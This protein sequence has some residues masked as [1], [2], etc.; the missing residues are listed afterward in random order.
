[1]AIEFLNGLDFAGDLELK[2]SDPKIILYDNSGANGTPNGEIVFSE[3]DNT[4]N[5][6]LRYNGFNDRFEYWGLISGTSTLVGYWNRSTGTSLHSVGTI[7]TGSDGTSANWKTAYDHSQDTHAPTNAEAN[8]QADWNETTNT[9]DAFILNKPTIPT[10]F[11]SKANG[12][13]FDGN[14]TVQD[15]SMGAADRFT[16]GDYLELSYGAS[17]T[18]QFTFNAD[19][20]GAQTGTY[21]PQ[22]SGT[23]SSGMSVV[24]MPSGGV[25]GLDFYVKQHGT[26]TGSHNISTFTKILELNQNGIS[27]FGANVV[28]K[29][30]LLPNA[31]TTYDIGSNTLKWAEGHFDHLFIGETGNNPRID[32]YTENGTASLADTFTDTSTDKSYIYFQAGTSSNDPGFIMHETSESS[33]P[34]ER[35]EGVLHLVP[36]DDNNYG[37]YVSIHGTNDPDA[38]KLHTS[39]AIET[40]ANYQLALSSGSGS[41]KIDDSLDVTGDITVA[42]TVDGVD[43]SALPT[44]FAPTNAEA[45]VQA[46]WNETTN[47]SDAF[48]LNK[49]TIPT[50]FV[51]AANGGTFSG[52]VTVS[53]ETSF[54]P[55][56]Y[57][58]TDDLNSDTRNIFSTHN[59]NNVTSNRPI[60]YSSVYT[61][62]GSTYN[63]LQISTNE[64]YSESGMWIRQ[65]NQNSASP[66][67]TGWQ[68]WAEVWTTNH[69]NL[70]KISEWN[71]AYT[72]SQAAH[73]PTNAEANVQADWDE[74][75]TTS[76]AFILNKPTTFAP[77]AH[78]H[79]ASEITSGTLSVSRLPSSVFLDRG[80]VNVTTTTGGS[81][82]DPF[83]NAHTETKIAENG[84]RAIIYTGA[85]AHL[86][87]SYTGGSASVFQLGAHYNG[88]DFYM[89]VRTD[90]SSWKD[91]RKLYHTGYKPTY[92]DLGTMAYSNLTGTPTIPAAVTDFVS[93][94]NGGTFSGDITISKSV[95]DSV[96]T[97]EADTDNNVENDNPRIELKQD[98]GVIYGHF[99]LNGDVN[100]TFTGATANSAYIRSVGSFHVATNSSTNALEID[101]SQNATFYG[102]VSVTSGKFQLTVNAPTN[103]TTTIVNSTIN[104]TFTASTTTNIDYY[105]VFSSV[106][107]GDYGLI[108]VI[109]PA[110]FGATMSIIDDSFDAT[111]TQAYRVYAVKNGVYSSP[112][113]GNK[114][115]S[116]TTPLE[117]TNMSVINLNTAYYVQWDPPSANTRFVTAY[118]VYKHEHATQGS[119]SRSSASLIYSGLNTSYMY[120]ISGANNGNFHQFWVETTIA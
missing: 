54:K 6:K 77:S 33:S 103:L 50:D 31:D 91:W 35:N 27:T 76:D 111:G 47:T 45:N 113:T 69:A 120:Q 25:G 66:Q 65:Y 118:N 38:L 56:H 13:T 57:A 92:T 102:N 86:F 84:S 42:G 94:A 24:K 48:I 106:D 101:A 73:A 64:D 79:A 70:G 90:G 100:S 59:V 14:I 83:D 71:T 80:D 30:D 116:V 11:V 16:H 108:S 10:D 104:V 20:D 114:S 93:K 15:I 62:G 98:S 39:G 109:P 95:G 112:L 119:L 43:I 19:Y 9:S 32:I 8:V 49:P 44:S 37:D 18:S 89:R 21:T 68:N 58:S 99:G 75:T 26:T 63:A 28:L 115:Y 72:H 46:D 34:D 78:N 53:G 60:N 2:K 87:S 107:G 85:S 22:Y 17:N 74:T 51:S 117:P 96:L 36:S 82:T 105:L 67:G 1:M 29:G 40:A 110:D 88:T 52:D 61:L 41:V 97:I 3:A 23:S 55:K 12:G 81:N 5:F 4:E 7:S